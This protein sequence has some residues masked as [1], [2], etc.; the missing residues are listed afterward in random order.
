MTIVT[1][2]EISKLTDTTRGSGFTPEH[3]Y[4]YRSYDIEA[5][6]EKSKNS[7]TV[8]VTD[9]EETTRPKTTVLGEASNKKEFVDL[10]YNYINKR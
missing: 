1:K 5:E 4:Y 7:T 10:V 6:F 2:T 9:L 3:S 8:Y